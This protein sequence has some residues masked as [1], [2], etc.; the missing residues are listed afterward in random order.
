MNMTSNTFM[1]DE[2]RNDDPSTIG[3]GGG[4]FGEA[5]S[6]DG[7]ATDVSSPLS[8]LEYGTDRPGPH[9]EDIIRDDAATRGLAEHGY[10]G[11]GNLQAAVDSDSNTDSD[12][13][14]VDSDT[15]EYSDGS[16]ENETYPAGDDKSQGFSTQGLGQTPGS[17]MRNSDGGGLGANL[18]PSSENTGGYGG[19]PDPAVAE[20]GRYDENLD[21]AGTD[22][23]VAGTGNL[24]D[25]VSDHSDSDNND[26]NSKDDVMGTLRDKLEDAKHNLFGNNHNR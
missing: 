1:N 24:R 22:E 4:D 7:T 6:P 26:G 19:N 16:F 13:P 18:S 23:N 5:D 12:R 2:N 25:D 11:T 20:T 14:P 3:L 15:E 17:V 10:D 21:S 8:S 9:D